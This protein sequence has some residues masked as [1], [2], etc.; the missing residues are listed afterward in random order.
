MVDNGFLKVA[1][2]QTLIVSDNIDDL[3]GQMN[4]YTAPIVEKWITK[5]TT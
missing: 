1:N 2:Q 3:L 5:E 4:S